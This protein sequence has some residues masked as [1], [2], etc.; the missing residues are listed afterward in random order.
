[1]NTHYWIL[2][3]HSGD[4]TLDG[5]K[6]ARLSASETSVLM[7][8]ASNE[9]VLLSKEQLLDS[10]WP[11]KVVSLSSLTVAIK[12]I[13]KALCA[14]TTPTYI[15]TVHRKGYIYHGEGTN[16]S[17]KEKATPNYE[18]KN[19]RDK[20]LY[21]NEDRMTL[22]HAGLN[23]QLC[24]PASPQ[25]DKSTPGKKYNNYGRI[26]SWGVFSIIYIFFLYLAILISVSK[27][28]LVCYQIGQANACGVFKLDNVDIKNIQ[29]KLNDKSGDYFY[30]H[31]K[32]LDELKIYQRN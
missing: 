21:D 22:D 31:T 8:L 15:E 9:G 20:S 23:E 12:N 5:Q 27:N 17:I 2:D 1:M 3:I 25:I 28:E 7:L 32:N 11:E 6:I 18:H 24:S 26:I 29:I 13:R 14:K 19:I 4:I 16:F 30:G 10:G